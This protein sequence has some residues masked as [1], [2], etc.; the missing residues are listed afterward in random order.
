VVKDINYYMGLKYPIEIREFDE[1]D[2]GGFDASIPMLGKYAFR[3]YGDTLEAALQS[4]KEVKREKFEY[5][6]EKGTLIDE[7]PSESERHK[8]YTGRFVLRIPKFLHR[9]LAEEA[10]ANGTSLNQ[11]CVYLL[12]QNSAILEK[13]A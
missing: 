2:G 13:S 8:E 1:E 12:S 11:Y 10:A 9:R 3:G 7:P 5:Y 4:L 6:L